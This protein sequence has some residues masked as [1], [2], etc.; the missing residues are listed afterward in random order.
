MTTDTLNQQLVTD[1]FY[2]GIAEICFHL[3]G[4]HLDEHS[5]ALL[6]GVKEATQN[7]FSMMHVMPSKY[8]V[9]SESKQLNMRIVAASRYIDSC[10][11][12]P[13]AEECASAKVL[14]DLFGSYGKAFARMKVDERIGA[15]DLLLRD[16]AKPAMQ[17]HV[18]KLVLLPER[19]TYIREAL[20][21]LMD[22]LFENDQAQSLEPKPQRLLD[23]KRDASE[24]LAALVSYL[25]VMSL[26]EPSTFKEHYGVVSEIIRRLN[27]SYTGG[28]PKKRK[29]AKKAKKEGGVVKLIAK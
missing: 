12:V 26:K 18:V 1:L 11:Y 29:K 9:Q 15:V 19:I 5:D 23:L 22:K 17:P 13:D 3:D 21:A 28:A 10:R 6:R 4:R 25:E 27:A 24:K 20:T 14:M 8:N 16:L 2:A 7:L